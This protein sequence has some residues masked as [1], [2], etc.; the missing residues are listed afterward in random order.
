MLGHVKP[1][2]VLPAA[3][4]LAWAVSVGCGPA[5]TRQGP[6]PPPPLDPMPVALEDPQTTAA[7]TTP[8]EP[9][10]APAPTASAYTVGGKS[11]SLVG[12][13]EL[14]AALERAGYATVGPTDPTACG[15]VEQ[16]QLNLTKRGAPGGTLSLLRAAQTTEANCTPTSIE[17]THATWRNAPAHPKSS[18]AMIHDQGANV[19]LVVNLMQKGTAAQSLLDAIVAKPTASADGVP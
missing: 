9:P 5:T 14:Q 11:L 17:E 1:L 19:L 12:A 16:L 7:H 15:D 8:G 3:C 13:E 6:P 4:A 2:A 18:I 10:P